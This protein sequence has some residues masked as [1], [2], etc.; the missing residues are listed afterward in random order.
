MALENLTVGF[1]TVGM[2]AKSYPAIAR[3]L[4]LS[5]GGIFV[6]VILTC[7]ALL[8]LAAAVRPTPVDTGTGAA[9]KLVGPV[10]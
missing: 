9:V 5:T 2:N 8:A 4:R 7:A 10:S 3:R 6:A 1:F